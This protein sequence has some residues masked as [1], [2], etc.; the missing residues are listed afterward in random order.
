MGAV[1]PLGTLAQWGLLGHRK[2]YSYFTAHLFL[3][4]V[5]FL[6]LSSLYCSYTFLHIVS[7]SI[8][9]H[10]FYVLVSILSF[11]PCTVQ[12]FDLI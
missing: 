6:V 12:L 9:P 5:H 7:Y 11:V 10:F 8:Y 4:C 2:S 3:S 1:G